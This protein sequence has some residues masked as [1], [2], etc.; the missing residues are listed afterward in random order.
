MTPE[1]D[2]LVAANLRLVHWTIKRMRFIP[3]EG[4]DTYED[5]VAD[6]NVGLVNAA[7]FYE[8]SKGRFSTFA[9]GWIR[10]ALF[11]GQRQRFEMSAN[12]S[13]A[14]AKG[15][16]L[17]GLLHVLR[18]AYPATS[19]LDGLVPGYARAER[20]HQ[21][22]FTETS[23]DAPIPAPSTEGALYGRDIIPSS[24]PDPATTA[25]NSV[26]LRD[27]LCRAKLDD[28]DRLIL[29]AHYFQGY[30]LPD[31]AL[32]LGI[33][34]TRVSQLHARALARL[35]EAACTPQTTP[36]TSSENFAARAPAAA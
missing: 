33:S 8:R 27:I 30:S 22:Y 11:H 25:T 34:Y 12:L 32:D 16:S 24:E 10:I 29:A 6:G 23:L 7:R 31:I 18:G 19:E 9:V 15:R 26:L 2:A 20:S 17:G 21:V 28:R 36:T 4:F 14:Y 35:R 5:L 3:R 1:Q 13:A